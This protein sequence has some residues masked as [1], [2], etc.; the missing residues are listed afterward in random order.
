[1]SSFFQAARWFRRVCRWN[2]PWATT[3]AWRLARRSQRSTRSTSV[4]GWSIPTTGA[5]SRSSS[6]TSAIRISRLFIYL[7]LLLFFFFA[8]IVLNE[9]LQFWYRVVFVVL[10]E[11]HILPFENFLILRNFCRSTSA[12]ASHSWSASGLRTWTSSRRTRS[13][14]PRTEVR[15]GS[16]PLE[17]RRGAYTNTVSTISSAIIFFYPCTLSLS[18]NPLQFHL[19]RYS[20]LSFFNN[21]FDLVFFP[22]YFPISLI[23]NK[24]IF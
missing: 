12:T 24:S 3:V 15:E 21:W 1:M 20:I 2:C 8:K 16:G 17:N 18:L 6:S 22:F 7:L 23:G 4:P 9:Q 5:S 19:T 11:A 13:C 14:R 10:I